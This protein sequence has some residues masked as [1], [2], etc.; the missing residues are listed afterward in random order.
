MSLICLVSLSQTLDATYFSGNIVRHNKDISHLITHHPE[1]LI[2]SYSRQTTEEDGWAKAYNYPA[3]GT[4]LLINSFKNK[5]IGFN[6][7]VFGHYNFYFLNRKIVFR[8]AQ[9]FALTEKKYNK[10]ENYRNVIFGSRVLASTYMMLNYHHPMLWKRWGFKTG[11]TFIHYS[12]GSFKSPNKGINTVNI[13]FGLT[14]ALNTN[15]K[16]SAEKL[17]PHLTPNENIRYQ[18][19]LS[20]GLNESDLIGSGQYP[21]FVLTTSAD[22]KINRKS[23]L[24]F[25]ADFF[26]SYFLKEHIKYYSVSFP[27]GKIDGDESFLR[28][29]VFL[30]HELFVSKWSVI[31]QVGYYI[32]NPIGFES[33][34][35]LRA[36]LKRYFNQ[37][38]FGSMSVKS[39][40]AKA[41]AIEWGIGVRL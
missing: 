2:L 22:K 8:I 34:I 19:K 3:L 12:N 30:G 32:F 37:H 29:G 5:F 16:T 14:Y 31:T 6:V 39:H 17:P 15:N 28:L 11:C 36:G 38:W 1:G 9:G 10:S 18:F 7:G 27:E 41:E 4:S 33:D 13:N 23:A 40:G 26:A 35:Y 24:Q 20:S 25:G 21:F